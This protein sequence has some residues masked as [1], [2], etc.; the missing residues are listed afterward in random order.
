MSSHN[1]FRDLQ[2]L[3]KNCIPYMKKKLTILKFMN[4]LLSY[5]ICFGKYVEW[6]L[7]IDY[8][9]LKKETT[10]LIYELRI[11]SSYCL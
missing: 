9:R 7:I 2:D 1:E 8:L 5:I 3:K 10:C 11:K 4:P 6:S